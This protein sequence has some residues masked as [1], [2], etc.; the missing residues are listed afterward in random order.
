M[1]YVSYWM[2]FIAAALLE[3][4]GDAIIRNG[5][6]GSRI[7][8][9]ISGCAMLGCYGL[10]VNILKWDF[11]RLLGVYVA[12]FALVSILFSRLMFRETIPPATWV[13]IIVIV[14]GGLI[15]QFGQP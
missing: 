4:G 14:V 7:V 3:V 12:V 6:R 11:G 8:L 2:I 9:I 5:L 15:I 10:V 13:G 1:K